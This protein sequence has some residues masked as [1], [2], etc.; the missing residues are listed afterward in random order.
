MFLFK[1]IILPLYMYCSCEKV[2]FSTMWAALIGVMLEGGLASPEA[3][4]NKSDNIRNK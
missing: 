4:T 3:S 2:L 1:V